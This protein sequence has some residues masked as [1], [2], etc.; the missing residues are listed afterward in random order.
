M[1]EH[2]NTIDAI[3]DRIDILITKAEKRSAELL[4][5][6][7]LSDEQGPKDT[8]DCARLIACN[9]N[10][11]FTAENLFTAAQHLKGL[12]DLCANAS[13]DDDDSVT[14]A[15]LLKLFLTVYDCRSFIDES[16]K[17]ICKCGRDENKS[18][19]HYP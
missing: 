2:T 15:R 13:S 14:D 10:R 3:I 17:C 12:R 5:Q 4:L 8:V 18:G 16:C 7:E 19:S 11:T 9:K 1:N 6:V